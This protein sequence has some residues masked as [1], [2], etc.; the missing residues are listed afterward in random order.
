MGRRPCYIAAD[1]TQAD[2]AAELGVTR[3]DVSILENRALWKLRRRLESMG[4]DGPGAEPA[5]IWDV[6]GE[7]EDT[8]R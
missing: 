1:R 7:Q 2:V 3:A 5:S 8:E 4:V 6:H